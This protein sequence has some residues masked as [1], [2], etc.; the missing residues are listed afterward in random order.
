MTTI[1]IP[2]SAFINIVWDYAEAFFKARTFKSSYNQGKKDAL[3]QAI[4]Y[5]WG[6]TSVEVQEMELFKDALNQFESAEAAWY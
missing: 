5:C 6:Y 4:N 2:S 1:K 3:M